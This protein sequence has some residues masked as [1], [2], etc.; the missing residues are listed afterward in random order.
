MTGSVTSTPPPYPY[1]ELHVI[2]NFSFLRGASHPEE[3]VQQAAALGYRAIAITDECSLAGVVRAYTACKDLDIQLIVGSEFQ[4]HDPNHPDHPVHL[5]LLATNRS[6]YAQLS[7]LITKGRRRSEKGRYTL[8]LADLQL[9]LEHCLAIW[10]PSGCLSEYGAALPVE[11]IPAEA[12]STTEVPPSKTGSPQTTSEESPQLQQGGQ[13]AG[14]FPQRLWL[15]V[16]LL[17]EDLEL[18]RYQALYHLA[19]S[20]DLPMVATNQVHLHKQERKTLQHTLTAIRCNTPVQQLGTQLHQNGERYLR[21]LNML[22][23]LY[24]MPLL[25]ETLV[26]ARRCHFELKEL[27]YEYP[28]ELV[29]NPLSASEYLRQLTYQGAAQRWPRK[30][31]DHVIQLLEKE[32]QLIAQLQY[33]YYF[34]TV[35]DI[36][37]FARSKQ[38]LCQG[39]GSAANSA[40]CYCLGITEVDP[41]R[42][43]VLFERF[44]SAERDEPPD[45]DVDFEHERREEVIQYIYK[46]YGRDRAALAATVITYRPRSAI[47]DVGKALGLDT[48]MIDQLAKS[49][50]W[51]DRK[52]ELMNRFKENKLTEQSRLANHF[53]QLVHD[54]LGFPRHLSQHVGG[55]VISSGP[56]HGLVPLE[57]A[58]MAER[59]IIQWDKMD[60]EALGLLKVDILALGMLTAI[61]KSIDLINSYMKVPLSVSRIPAEDPKT[62]DMLCRGDSIG[63]FQVESRAQMSMLPRLKPRCYYDLVIEVAIVRP[64][65]IQGNMV[66]PYL[67]RR[68]G[69]EP[70]EY[71]NDE[72]KTVLERTL[73]VPIFQEQAI[74]LSMVAAGFSG[75]EADQLR[76][77]M[78]SWGRNGDL[79]GFRSKLVSGMLA[80]GYDQEFAERI[81]RQIQGFGG[82]GFPESHSA[83]FALLVYISAWLKRHYPA[84]FFCGMLNSLPMGFYAPAQLIQDAKRHGV[85]IHPIDVDHSHWDHSLELPPNTGNEEPKPALRLGFRLVKGFSRVAADTI[86]RERQQQRFSNLNDLIYRTHLNKRDLSALVDANALQRIAGHRYQAHWDS[87]GIEERRPLL[88]SL[89]QQASHTTH[90]EVHLS[91]PTEEEEMLAD[92]DSTSLTLGR[93][94]LALLRETAPFFRCKK[95]SDLLH[96]NQGRFVRIAGLVTCRQRPGTAAGVLFLTLEDETGHINVVVWKDVQLRHRAQLL[97]GKLLLVKGTLETK[98]NVIHVIAGAIEDHSTV[99]QQITFRSRDFH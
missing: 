25:Q 57:N 88:T 12:T 40:V 47:R 65:P 10:H 68:N 94:P 37:H 86:V 74:Q 55:F 5:V 28:K 14:Y 87:Q 34:L 36:V 21:P 81:F 56:I 71:Y 82:Y 79:E 22:Q 35:Y 43:E 75:G 4:L 60:L 39:R 52:N 66:H 95:A 9:G 58:A 72:I 78:A 99:L 67:R 24:P 13:L 20:L 26:I 8:S 96:L 38:I 98:D 91:A 19:G 92:Y 70:V 48:Q 42:C 69:E 63:V 51:W 89:E 29:P 46:K 61:R 93:H 80:R 90:D 23:A 27:R 97:T 76:R 32:L 77:A 6:G 16:T 18:E 45:I 31:P 54:I 59:T 53:Y 84:A 15:G 3:M 50:A 1:A 17:Q 85:E 62:Y 44:I 83:S 41:D 11:T 49:L 33:E 73:G 2:T 64:G 30:V 7:G